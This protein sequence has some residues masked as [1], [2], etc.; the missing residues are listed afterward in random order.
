MQFSGKYENI[1]LSG[2]VNL[3][4]TCFMN[5]ALQCL[6]NTLI[7]TDYFLTKKY[8]KDLNQEKKIHKLA[9][10]Y[11]NLLEGIWSENCTI[12]P[13]SFFSTFKKNISN[14][15]FLGFRQ[16]DMQEFLLFFIDGLHESLSREVE[17]SISGEPQNE[18]DKMAIEAMSVWK[19]HFKNNYSKIIEIFYGQFVSSIYTDNQKYISRTYDPVCYFTL[20]I[21]ENMKNITIYDCFDRYTAM[22]KMTGNTQWYCEEVNKKLDA[23]KDI[24]IWSFPKVLIIIFKRFRNNS[25]KI[26]NFINF[27]KNNMNLSKYCVGYHK[28]ECNYDLVGI[29]NHTGNTLGGHYFSYCKNSNNKWYEYNDSRVEELDNKNIISNKAYCLFYIK[30]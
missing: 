26:D 11:Y 4:N 20:S 3:G 30:K 29:C 22:E 9:I 16:N 24:K 5:S 18:I 6:S 8:I 27:P 13:N 15:E 23:N 12:S 2:L 10:D 19:T 7:L 14:N 21:P 28:N 25:S 17:I 1:G